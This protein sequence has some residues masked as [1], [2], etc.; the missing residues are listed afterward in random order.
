[1]HNTA[2]PALAIDRMPHVTVLDGLRAVAVGIVF[3][4]HI[5]LFKAFPG[6]FGVT[7]FFFLSGFLIT[8]LLRLERAKTGTV[9]LRD[10][11]LRRFLRIN[12]PLWMAMILAA[13][14]VLLGLP[15]IDLSALALTGQALFFSNYLPGFAKDDGVPIPLWSLAVE[16]HFYLVFPLFF[17]M[18]SR[19][20]PVRTIAAVCLGLCVVVMGIRFWN[21]LALGIVEA[22]YYWTHTRIDS[23]LFGC[24]LALWGNPV[25]ER[26]GWRPGWLALALAIG[27][28]LLSF[29]I[30]DD[31]FREGARYTLQGVA[32]FVLFAWVMRAK[33]LVPWLLNHPL[34]QRIGLYSY[35]I[36][37]IHYPLILAVK[38]LVPGLH[39]LGVGLA[40]G[41]G[42]MAVGWAINVAI[43][44][45]AARM[46]RRLNRVAA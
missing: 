29:A 45:P 25:A 42:S 44:Q 46:R 24:V 22:N 40:A 16:E 9:S 3:V 32:L 5:G 43:E 12:P 28:V 26:D 17:L 8:T 34:M 10:F 37:L 15:H 19:R 36:Y 41:L 1:M 7:I 35:T 13:G 18:L 27:A 39:P 38:A 30:R 11:Y 2:D 20:L 14:L 23:I 21:L 31:I 6:G 33:G 4:G